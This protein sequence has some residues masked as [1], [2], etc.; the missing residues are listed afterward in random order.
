MHVGDAEGG[1][2]GEVGNNIKC[3][4]SIS[5]YSVFKAGNGRNIDY[6]RKTLAYLS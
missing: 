2:W 1:V 4:I 3:N 5:E 6:T